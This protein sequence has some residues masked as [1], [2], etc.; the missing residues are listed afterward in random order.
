MTTPQNTR[1]VVFD[2]VVNFGVIEKDADVATVLPTTP[3]GQ[4]EDT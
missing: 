2:V 3:T 4:H 1:D